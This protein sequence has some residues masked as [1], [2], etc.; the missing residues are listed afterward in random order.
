[1]LAAASATVQT[2]ESGYDLLSPGGQKV[3][4][5]LHVV[6]S[7]DGG[8]TKDQLAA[9]RDDAGWGKAFKQMQADGHYEGY[10]NLGQ[11]ISEHVSRKYR[12]D[13]ARSG[14]SDRVQARGAHKIHRVSRVDRP[15]R[16]H[17]PKRR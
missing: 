14:K 11:V 13:S 1:M 12:A 3:V 8:L 16:P 9:Y 7:G 17:R 4:D 5:A 10:K 2:A 6:Q 15:K